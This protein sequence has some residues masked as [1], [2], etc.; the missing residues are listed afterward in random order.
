MSLQLSEAEV[1]LA[2]RARQMRFERERR[3]FRRAG[4]QQLEHQPVFGEERLESVH[5]RG[6]QS[7][8]ESP[9]QRVSRNLKAGGSRADGRQALAHIG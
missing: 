7:K 2:L 9:S 1:L 5:G 4:E 3:R 6:L 8:L